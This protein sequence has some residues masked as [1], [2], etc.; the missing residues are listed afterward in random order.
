[1]TPNYSEEKLFGVD[2]EFFY[3]D[4]LSFSEKNGINVYNYP[5]RCDK[6]TEDYFVSIIV[7]GELF[8]EMTTK[9]DFIGRDLLTLITSLGTGKKVSLK[10]NRANILYLCSKLKSSNDYPKKSIESSDNKACEIK[11]EGLDMSSCLTIKYM[12]DN[13]IEKAFKKLAKLL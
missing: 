4:L 6:T 9:F 13:H 3:R 2:E 11:S 8:I 10:E 12:L 1:M 5:F 7:S